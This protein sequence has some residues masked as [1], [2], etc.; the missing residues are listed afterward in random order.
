MY[1]FNLF[2]LTT[3]IISLHQSIYADDDGGFKRPKTHMRKDPRDYTDRDVDSLY[4]E[5]E[6]K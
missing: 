2:T 3:I 6:V 1:A 5:W 4:D